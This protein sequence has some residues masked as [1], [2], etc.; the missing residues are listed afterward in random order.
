MASKYREIPVEQV[1]D[2]C[3]VRYRSLDEVYE[4]KLTLVF[5]SL[6]CAPSRDND[7]RQDV[8]FSR[9]DDGRF[10]QG[11][12]FFC[13][14]LHVYEPDDGDG[15]DDTPADV[16]DEPA[17]EPE[18]PVEATSEE[19]EPPCHPGDWV[20]LRY[21]INTAE[22]EV[23]TVEPCTE[24]DGV[25]HV[26]LKSKDE[27]CPFH[28]GGGDAAWTVEKVTPR[29]DADGL[30]NQTGFYKDSL[31]VVWKW[32]GS[33]YTPVIDKD[34]NP[35]NGNKMTPLGR[36]RFLKTMSDEHRLPFTKV[37]FTVDEA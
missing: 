31:G 1:H 26:Y 8:L 20:R 35:T 18:E 25:W 12:F 36:A 30:P 13:T 10:H 15:P 3:W 16:K 22:S 14:E 32:D 5:G 6:L 11:P 33:L 29:F 17:S 23:I 24:N 27:D 37:R 28:V 2:G 9:G 7:N 21:D 34:G 19:P 4:G